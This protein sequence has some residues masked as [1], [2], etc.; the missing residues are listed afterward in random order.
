LF[1]LFG[2]TERDT[3]SDL[4]RRVP[5]DHRRQKIN[6]KKLAYFSAPKNVVP[7]HRVSHPS[8]HKFT[9]K[10]PRF[11]HHFFANPHKKSSKTGPFAT[12]H[13]ASKKTEL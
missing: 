9:I 12:A 7:N 8:H 13:H 2:K 3:G 5:E 11:G 1:Y 10:S 6:F 4:A